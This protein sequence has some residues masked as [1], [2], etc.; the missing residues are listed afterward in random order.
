MAEMT[1]FKLS[2]VQW[3]SDRDPEK[4]QK[5]MNDVSSMVRATRYGPPLE[6]FLDS[7]LGRRKC[8]HTTTPSFI[9]EDSD[10]CATE[11]EAKGEGDNSE[12]E[13][14]SSGGSKGSIPSPS[15]SSSRSLA[16]APIPY[17]GLPEESKDLDQLL[18]NVIIM[19]VK[20][21]KASL[22][23]CVAFPSYVQVMCVLAKHVDI[24]HMQRKTKAIHDMDGL[25]Y[26]GD[27]QKYQIE[28]MQKVAG[29]FDSKVT[30]MDY[31]L[32]RIMASF[33][34]KNKTIQH[35]IARDINERGD[36]DDVNIYDMIQGYCSE[37]ASAHRGWKSKIGDQHRE[38]KVRALR[39]ER[40]CGKR[41]STK[42]KRVF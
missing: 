7:K 36:E 11:E 4:F 8:A 6:D 12:M 39:K 25:T 35:Q 16:E 30:I 26:K 1:K 10:F 18:Y 34:G 41:L 33:D 3:D 40:T 19:N 21:T 37:I 27:V 22:L 24:S 2:A 29:I 31:I 42:E 32:M 14:D 13:A 15:K 28:A 23:S 17:F 38:G 20:G 9:T 5:W